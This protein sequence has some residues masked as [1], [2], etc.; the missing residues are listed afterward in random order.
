MPP[1]SSSRRREP[2]PEKPPGPLSPNPWILKLLFSSYRELCPLQD[3]LPRHLSLVRLDANENPLG[4]SPLA[5]E[6]IR[7][8]AEESHR[9]PEIAGAGL[10]ELVAAELGVSPEQ[11][12]F[13]S[14]STELL[15]LLF[16]V[17]LRS[18]RD[19][20]V[21]PRHSFPLYE[22]L[23][24]RFG[25]RARVAPDRNFVVDLESLHA[26][27]TPRTRLIFLANPNNPTGTYVD[28]TALLDFARRLPAHVLLALDEAYADYLED[29]PHLASAIRDG[30]PIVALRTFSKLHGLASLRIGYAL[31]S[32]A[33]AHALQ[34]AALPTNT[35]GIAQGAAAAALKDRRHQQES[36]KVVQ[37]GRLLLERSFQ[38]SGL[39][40]VPSSAN[41]VMVRLLHAEQV[42]KALVRRGVLVRS[43]DSWGLPGW[44]RVTA[45]RPHE[46][47]Q[48]AGGL[49]ATLR[50]LH[51]KPPSPAQEVGVA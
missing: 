50:E 43:L 17:F 14:G 38:E 15:E 19:E 22:M 2:R 6:A 26:A 29:P 48:F 34:K 37:E 7:R 46:L 9:Y 49:H 41:F 3:L 13:G 47:L 5:R 32:P 8:A 24:Q 33:M 4:P 36:K 21:V 45:G 10:R 20:V 39:T 44:L 35:S 12:V 23:A 30:A 16:H 31:A 40:W 1:S 18:R 28:N 51:G 25:C 42:W 11:I 27:I